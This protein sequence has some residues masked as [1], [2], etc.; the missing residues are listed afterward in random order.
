MVPRSLGARAFNQMPKEDKSNE[1]QELND[2]YR[3]GVRE[4]LTTS[5]V[6]KLRPCS[7]QLRAGSQAGG[8]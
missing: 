4:D 3:H 7:L 8:F 1:Q 2:S 5:K 6:N